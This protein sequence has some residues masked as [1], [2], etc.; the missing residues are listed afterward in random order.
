[1]YKLSLLV[2][3]DLVILFVGRICIWTIIASRKQLGWN[4]YKS[5]RKIHFQIC[6][7][8]NYRGVSLPQWSVWSAR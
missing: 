5:L 7:Q 3:R 4:E 1:M 8:D 2:R 6:G